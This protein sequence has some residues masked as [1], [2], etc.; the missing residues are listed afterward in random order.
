[1]P[2]QGF[3]GTNVFVFPFN[4]SRQNLSSFALIYGDCANPPQ[5]TIVLAINQFYSFSFP[6]LVGYCLTLIG[7]LFSCS[8]ADICSEIS[9]K[10]RERTS[11]NI[12]SNSALVFAEHKL[13]ISSIHQNNSLSRHV[14]QTL[15]KP[16]PEGPF[17]SLSYLDGSSR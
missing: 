17:H 13:A 9:A 11:S 4:S 1:M 15:L 8:T 6:S 14:G 2:D 7:S 10:I 5:R 3:S 12:V 16:L